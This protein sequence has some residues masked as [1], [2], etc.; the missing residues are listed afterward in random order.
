MRQRRR[1]HT[2]RRR[3]IAGGVATGVLAVARP[4]FAQIVTPAEAV[5]A[6]LAPPPLSDTSDT[7]HGVVVRDPFRAAWKIQAART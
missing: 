2:T 7:F 6:K 1:F 5:P 4:A 3:F